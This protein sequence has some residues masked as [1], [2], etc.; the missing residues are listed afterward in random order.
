MLS[1]NHLCMVVLNCSMVRQ[2]TVR[3]CSGANMKSYMASS[4]SFV[5]WKEGEAFPFDHARGPRSGIEG[6]FMAAFAQYARDG[7]RLKNMA[8]K[9]QQ[10]MRN[11]AMG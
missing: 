4:S 9:D 2:F 3:V 11:L 1:S 5:G 8:G 10:V 6:A 7:Q